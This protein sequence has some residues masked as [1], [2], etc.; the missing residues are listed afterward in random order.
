VGRHIGVSPLARAGAEAALEAGIE[1]TLVGEAALFSHLGELGVAISQQGNGFDQPHLHSQGGH[2]E[3]KVLM[4]EAVQ[5][6]RGA[7]ESLGQF[8][9]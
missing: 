2:G 7:M 8:R 1:E 6:A 4:K 5:M 9:H 3:A